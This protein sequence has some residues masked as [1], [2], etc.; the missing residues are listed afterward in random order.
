MT[1]TDTDMNKTLDLA[2]NKAIFIYIDEKL[3]NNSYQA[4]L[5]NLVKF[6][7]GSFDHLRIR[8]LQISHSAFG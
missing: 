6:C 8:V 4:P 7:F 5:S 2:K 1:E 3:Y